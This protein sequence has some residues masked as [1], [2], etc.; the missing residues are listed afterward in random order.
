M[1]TPDRQLGPEQ[2]HPVVI[3]GGGVCG[4]TL[5]LMLAVRRVPSV[6]LERE[7][8]PQMLPRAHTVNPRTRE[9]LPE[10]GVGAAELRAIAAPKELTNEVRFVTTLTG[11]CFGTL[12]FE[13]QDDAVMAVTPAP[14]LNVPQPALEAILFDRVAHEPLIDFR[15][16]HSWTAG[17]QDDGGV[18]TS[19]VV[20][21]DGEY[22]IASRYLVG[23]DG[24]SSA[25]R[26]AFG[27][28]MTGDG[29]IAAA[30]TITFRADLTDL[31]RSRPGVLHWVLGTPRPVVLL[32]YYPDRL[33]GLTVPMPPG[34]VDMSQFGEDRA[35]D[36][37]RAAIGPEAADLPIDIIA[38]TPW[39]M[40]REVA[41]RYRVG[42]V[43]LAGDAAHRFPPTG[44]LGVNTGI[45]DVHNLAWKLAAVLGGWAGDALLDTYDG[46]RR[47][48]AERNARQSLANMREIDALQILEEPARF[49]TDSARFHEWLDDPGH[50]KLVDD[51][52]ERQ[53]AHFDSLALQLGF[54]YAP[55]APPVTDVGDFIPCARPG[56]RFPHGWLDPEGRET[57]TLDLLDP[58]AFT[59]VRLRDHPQPMQLALNEVPITAV[60]LNPTQPRVAAWMAEVGLSEDTDVVVRP[61]GHILAIETGA[62]AI[63]AEQATRGIADFLATPESDSQ[64]ELTSTHEG[65]H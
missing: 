45:Q 64:L 12:P 30:V 50:T 36:L 20:S 56:M 39:K 53:R 46:E 49:A 14:M 16:G 2:P 60:T 41:D 1:D 13:R 22:Q 29:D 42:N 32:S 38:A 58:L 27:V 51:A 25:V 19:T 47:S 37:V 59:V 24:A 28:T 11:H 48:V 52:V 4:V 44:G 63:A 8:E 9:I 26:G 55:D 65:K 57:S 33:W 23:T 40:R 31:V 3:S 5:A 6:V 17:S 10:V 34:K 18:V 62:D 54:S 35:R 43:F 21:A 7:L 61:D 15:R